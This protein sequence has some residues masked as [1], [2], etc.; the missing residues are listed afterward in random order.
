[1]RQ[2]FQSSLQRLCEK[3]RIHVRLRFMMGRPTTGFLC[4]FTLNLKVPDLFEENP[5]W[6]TSTNSVRWCRHKDFDAE[7]CPEH[8]LGQLWSLNRIDYPLLQR[9]LPVIS[10]ILRVPMHLRGIN[11]SSKHPQHWHTVCWFFASHCLAALSTKSSLDLCEHGSY[12][13]RSC[14]DNLEYKAMSG[15][16]GGVHELLGLH[17]L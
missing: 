6:E 8:T 10:M 5:S 11:S 12:L 9:L 2:S 16:E 3:Y 14:L 7:N 15:C 13:H 17:L 1:M 4:S